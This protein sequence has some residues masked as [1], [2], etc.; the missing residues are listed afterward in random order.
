[1]HGRQ[2]HSRIACVA[3]IGMYRYYSRVKSV[4]SYEFPPL[5]F[6]RSVDQKT[7]DSGIDVDCSINIGI[8]FSGPTNLSLLPSPLSIA[9]LY[10]SS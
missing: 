2:D 9:A 8:Q 3:V 1:M 4:M 10:N 5:L 6:S 7:N